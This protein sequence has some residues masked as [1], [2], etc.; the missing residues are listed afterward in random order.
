MKCIKNNWIITYNE[1]TE[2]VELNKIRKVE[3]KQ[4]IQGVLCC[5]LL[6]A[7]KGNQGLT[8]QCGALTPSQI[9]TRY[10]EMFP[11]K[12]PDCLRCPWS[13]SW[14][15]TLSL[16][17]L[18]SRTWIEPL[19]NIFLAHIIQS[20]MICSLACPCTVSCRWIVFV[21]SLLT[22]PPANCDRL[23]SL[24]FLRLNKDCDVHTCFID[25]DSPDGC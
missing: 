9:W 21:L 1:E 3:S 23:R 25:S 5:Y 10:L 2:G 18:H 19:H 20:I 22:T 11:R 8:G 12:S 4:R 17:S 13:P 14:W 6:N 24:C 7:Q 16:V 15:F